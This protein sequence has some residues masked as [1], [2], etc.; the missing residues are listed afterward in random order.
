M[1][2][3]QGSRV[4]ELVARKLNVGCRLGLIRNKKRPVELDLVLSH[5][6]RYAR[7]GTQI[8]AY[9]PHLLRL[10]GYAVLMPGKDDRH[11]E[12]TVH[13]LHIDADQNESLRAANSLAAGLKV[14]SVLWDSGEPEICPIEVIVKFDGT[15]IP[16]KLD[17]SDVQ[18]LSEKSRFIAS[19][20]TELAETN[21]AKAQKLAQHEAEVEVRKEDRK[22]KARRPAR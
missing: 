17:A 19:L 16:V 9:R 11:F 13:S 8:P 20:Y 12:R 3:T 7:P 4:A 1:A 18:E 2:T 14:E 21:S 6:R 22:A 10:T 5:P 15:T